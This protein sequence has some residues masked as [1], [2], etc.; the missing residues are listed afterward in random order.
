V[1]D[2]LSEFGITFDATGVMHVDYND[3]T[4]VF[5]GEDY[6]GGSTNDVING[7]S[8]E[9]SFNGGAGDDTLNGGGGNDTLSGG[10]GNDLVEASAQ[11]D[12]QLYGGA[13]DDIL[14]LAPGGGTA[15]KNAANHHTIFE[16]G[17][18]NDRLQGYTSADTYVFN[19]G[20]GHDTILDSDH[21]ISAITTKSKSRYNRTKVTT[22]SYSSF[23][24][25]DS[26]QFGEGITQADLL[27]GR[28][29]QSLVIY[30]L[31]EGAPTDDRVTVERW[32]DS[33]R[34]RI[35]QITFADGST[36]GT[37]A[38]HQHLLTDIVTEGDDVISITSI[39]A[40]NIAS[41]GG[42]DCVTTGNENDTIYG[43]DGNDTLNGGNGD[44]TIYG[45]TGSDSIDGG[46]YNDLLD[47]G[48]GDDTLNGGN[49]NNTVYGGEGN[50]VITD[51][52]N[53]H[54]DGGAGNDV[55]DGY[56]KGNNTLIGGAGDDTITLKQG[57]TSSWYNTARSRT[58]TFTGGTGNDYLEGS[59]SADTY[60]FNKGDG[61]D[62]INNASGYDSQDTLLF[63]EGITEND[64]WF[65]SS[66][67]N[68]T[69]G[70]I[71]SEDNVTVENWNVSSSY[72]IEEI[73]LNDGAVLV[74]S[75]VQLLVDAM[76]G[77][78]PT[79]SGILTV[80]DAIQDQAQSVIAA[81][82]DRSA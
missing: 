33:D 52:G 21:G 30:L 79:S 9:E 36:M 57:R 38:I 7:S 46:N 60:V 58:N 68:L 81:N 1:T 10:D 71:G 17:T 35:E 82:W 28:D 80:P 14:Q 24:S 76:S 29:G 39:G 53:G 26:I 22:Y 20:D 40:V 6:I 19:R 56:V 27:M 41:L 73:K 67:N 44:D 31:R 15:G 2:E 45:G 32:F 34:Y 18:G 64:L 50:D 25:T 23:G 55:I 75:K 8:S 59:H 51:Y 74:E 54:L 65:T 78:A 63:G 77:Y 11:N 48:A 12:N 13:G 66:G 5:L 16:G 42:N 72:R 37:D 47:G 4:R 69:I 3:T 43:G 70:V 62:T 49:G 61:L